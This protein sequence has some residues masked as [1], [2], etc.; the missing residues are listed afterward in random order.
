MPRVLLIEDDHMVG[1]LTAEFLRENG[2]EVELCTDG[3]VGRE[4]ILDRQP[5]LVVLD[6]MLPG[7]DGLSICR[8]VRPHYSGPIL[9]LTALG[10][11]GDQV[12]G[13]E[14][15]ADDY[16]VKPVSPRVLL[17]RINALLR[18]LS[19]VED[20]NPVVEVGEIRLDPAAREATLHG[21][22][23][24][25]TT[26]EF[27]LLW[28]LAQRAGE[29]VP[30]EDLFR[31]LRGIPYDRHDRSIDVRVSQLRRKLEGAGARKGIIKTIRGIGYQ[32]AQPSR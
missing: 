21:T 13:L 30:R 23:F 31:E 11:E 20:T 16:V 27:D 6:R 3:A 22:P 17:A 9:M 5:D 29:P 1:P 32:L 8:A 4:R 25:L 19:L 18:R 10:A 7:E 28:L 15:G 12:L 2:I 14:G 26:S 24:P